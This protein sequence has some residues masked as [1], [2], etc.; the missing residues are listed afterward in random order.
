MRALRLA[1]VGPEATDRLE[2][3][4]QQRAAWRQRVSD[5]NRER[6]A[7]LSQPGLADSDRASAVQA[8]LEERFDHTEQLRLS[9]IE[10]TAPES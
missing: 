1:L 7:I 8:L 6:E 9:A 5:F 2:T 3:L 4:D 10:P